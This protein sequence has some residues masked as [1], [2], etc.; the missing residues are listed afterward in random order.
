MGGGRIARTFALAG[1]TQTQAKLSCTAAQLRG[2]LR[3]LAGKADD[4][5]LEAA[6]IAAEFVLRPALAGDRKLREATQGIGQ[7]D[8]VRKQTLSALQS[9]RSPV[10]DK[11]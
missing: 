2:R 6:F 11:A 8:K 10:K 1:I 4:R 7:R 5:V 3:D 9:G